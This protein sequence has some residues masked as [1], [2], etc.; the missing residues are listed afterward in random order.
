MD[1]MKFEHRTFDFHG[2]FICRFPPAGDSRRY[3]DV[4]WKELLGE[5]E[6]KSKEQNLKELGF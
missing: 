2:V 3:D 4:F 5:K 1:I 6:K